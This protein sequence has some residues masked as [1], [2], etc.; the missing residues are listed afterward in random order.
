MLFEPWYEMKS[1]R[2]RESRE[3]LNELNLNKQIL[4]TILW[5][6]AMKNKNFLLN[7]IDLGWNA[8]KS[9]GLIVQDEN[10]GCHHKF[11]QLHTH[12]SCYFN[13]S[14]KSSFLND[15]YR[16]A[17]DESVRKIIL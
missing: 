7:K 16:I 3:S 4:D 6:Q 8:V 14:S 12:T 5:N 9:C 13:G 10:R 2:S 1:D 15:F 17:G 11:I